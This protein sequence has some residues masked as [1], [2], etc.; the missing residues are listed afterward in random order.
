[1]IW[2]SKHTP[3]LFIENAYKYNKDNGLFVAM[4]T[5][6]TV[7]P[8][9]NVTEENLIRLKGHMQKYPLIN[10]KFSSLNIVNTIYNNTIMNV[11]L[12][13]W[14]EYEGQPK[15]KVHRKLYWENKRNKLN[16]FN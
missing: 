8:F 10:L 13:G 15:I 5:N 1:M 4:L 3:E 16:N 6:Q 11:W 7:G 12:G 9:S 14:K 2:L